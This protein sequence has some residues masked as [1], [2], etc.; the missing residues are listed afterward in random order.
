MIMITGKMNLQFKIIDRFF[1]T[2]CWSKGRSTA[3]DTEMLMVVMMAAKPTTEREG[4]Q[5]GSSNWR[6]RRWMIRRT[7]IR[8][9]Q[10]G[11]RKKMGGRAHGRYNN[12]RECLGIIMVLG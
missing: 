6:G 2:A 4:G 5:S 10:A 9:V 11:K 12:M 8:C 1:S 7:L 3:V